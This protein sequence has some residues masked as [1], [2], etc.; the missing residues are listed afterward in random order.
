MGVFGA[1]GVVGIG[2]VVVLSTVG[3]VV[4]LMVWK[5]SLGG[6]AAGLTQHSVLVVCLS[7]CVSR[8][9]SLC[10]SVCLSVCLRAKQHNSSSYGVCACV[11]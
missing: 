10:V 2:S 8:C 9:V 1:S 4:R 6:T 11:C 3:L 7:V 5:V